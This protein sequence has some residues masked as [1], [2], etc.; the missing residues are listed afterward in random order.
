MIALFF[1]LLI[2]SNN[3]KP[4]IIYQCILWTLGVWVTCETIDF[5]FCSRAKLINNE[6]NQSSHTTAPLDES[7]MR[8]LLLLV[9]M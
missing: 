4:E 5:T 9:I 2:N 8:Q 6:R 3:L 7:F 1:V